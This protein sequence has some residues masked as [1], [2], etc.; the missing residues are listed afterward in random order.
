M[1]KPINAFPEY[2]PKY[3]RLPNG[4]MEL[5]NIFRGVD[6]GHGGY[7]YA[8]PGMYVNVALLDSASHH[9]TSAINL[10]YFGEYTPIYKAILDIRLAI[11][12]RDFESARQMFDGKLAAYLDDPAKA[13]QLAQALKIVVNSTYGV[14][15]ASYQNAFTH[16]D[17]INNI[18]ALRGA[19]FIKML[20]DAVVERGF[21]MI[22]AKTD[23]IKIPNATPEIIQ[24]VMD[25]GK[26]YGYTFEHEATY[27]RMCLVN[28]A[29][30]IAK[31]A[32]AEKCERLYGYAP[33]KNKRKG[34][35]WDPTGAQFAHPVVFKTLFS[36]QPIDIW[37]YAETK[38]VSGK[39]SKI[40]LDYNENLPDITVYDM[41]KADREKERSGGKPRK[42]RP[43][44][45]LTDEELDAKIA[46]GHAYK[47]VGKVGL[48][49]PVR[50]G[51]G[52]GELM[53][54]RDGKY[55]AVAG[56]KGYRW[57]EFETIRAAHTEDTIDF[58]YYRKLVD[59]AKA[60]ISEYG[61]FEWFASEDESADISE[62]PLPDDHVPWLMPC[63]DPTKNTCEDCP[64]REHCQH[65]IQEQKMKEE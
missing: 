64:D 25:Y 59:D 39:D 29:V 23:S 34:G 37:D 30:Y 56:S 13:E 52:G 16:P 9:P 57:E 61:D 55:S 14:S 15:S 20:Q 51:C 50:P 19:I 7:V 24:F 27:D 33:G 3:V 49:L 31:F 47:F 38:E 22:H 6:L 12:H 40:Y 5:Q 41:E 48:Y 11:K 63:K 32:T 44:S 46:K 1:G 36:K 58:A 21:S 42:N 43:Y 45:Y 54:K 26:E 4:K 65:Y 53:V 2:T 18:I 8:E 17:N 10:N 60:A 35:K 62:F 28:N